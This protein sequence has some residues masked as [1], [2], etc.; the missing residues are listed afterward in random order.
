MAREILADVGDEAEAPEQDQEQPP[1]RGDA[2]E[3]LSAAE[4]AK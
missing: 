3:L 1:I 2:P 4:V